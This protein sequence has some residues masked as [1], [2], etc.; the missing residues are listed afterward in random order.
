MR[1]KKNFLIT[2]EHPLVWCG[3]VR[4]LNACC[5]LIP[6]NQSTVQEGGG[7]LIASA[8]HAYTYH[9]LILVISN[10]CGVPPGTHREFFSRLDFANLEFSTFEHENIKQITLVFFFTQEKKKERRD[11]QNGHGFS[12]WKWVHQGDCVGFFSVAGSL[13]EAYLHIAE[14]CMIVCLFTTAIIQT[15]W[16][17]GTIMTIF[18]TPTNL[19]GFLAY[20]AGIASYWY[21][22]NPGSRVHGSIDCCQCA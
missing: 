13:L 17:D 20:M 14:R 12:R 21:M 18:A 11:L 4:R 3:C 6:C 8:W 1:K 19:I 16:M 5:M 15:G 7:R 9:L 22:C 10:W 2:C